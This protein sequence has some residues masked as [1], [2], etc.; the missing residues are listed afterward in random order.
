[1][2][3]SPI[4]HSLSPALHR[5]AYQH[6]GLDWTYDARECTAEDLPSLL[7]AAG[8]DPDWAGFSL[9]MPLKLTVLP[10]LSFLD[11]AA[12][13]IGAVNTV[14]PAGA[15]ARNRLRGANTDAPGMVAALQEAGVTTVRSATVLGAGG[16]AQA[17]LAALADLGDRA[18]TVLVRDPGR[19]ASLLAA[20]GRLGVDPVLRRWADGLPA[21]T[22]LVLSTVPAGA[23]DG[24][25]GGSQGR[26]PAGA[27]LFDVVYV[28]WP[29][30]LAAAALAAG[31]TVVSGLDL[32]V[33]QARGQIEL[34]TGRAVGADVL[35]RALA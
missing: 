3:G 20:A 33:H 25:A 1:V 21:A 10:L 2:L 5:A 31:A 16:T 9:T 14:V 19:A 30:P 8:A 29:T 12:T 15:P 11:P 24:I 32:L 26:W 34:M 7:H 23:A 28:P 18:P 27:A 35:R 6:L 4:A 17:A 22:D 13:A